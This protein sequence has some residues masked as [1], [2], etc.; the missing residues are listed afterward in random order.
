MSWRHPL[1]LERHRF[2]LPKVKASSIR[3]ARIEIPL[4]SQ[5]KHSQR[6]I[7]SNPGRWAKLSGFWQHRTCIAWQEYKY[8]NILSRS[9]GLKCTHVHISLSLSHAVDKWPHKTC[10]FVQ[11]ERAPSVANESARAK[12][13][14]QCLPT[15]RKT[16]A[17]FVAE[18]LKRNK[19][20]RD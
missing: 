9:R 4:E 18:K 5:R 14:I 10:I 16:M 11:V 1:D 7:K 8:R 3:G 6:S 13:R 12:T 19:W 20:R 2:E 17:T 15:E